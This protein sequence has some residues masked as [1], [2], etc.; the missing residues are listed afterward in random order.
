MELFMSYFVPALCVLIIGTIPVYLLRIIMYFR[1]EHFI[2]QERSFRITMYIHGG[3]YLAFTLGMILV[4]S[5]MQETTVAIYIYLVMA[6]VLVCLYFGYRYQFNHIKMNRYKV[7]Y[8]KWNNRDVWQKMLDER[9]LAN[10]DITEGS[11]SFVSEIHFTSMK[12]SEIRDLLNE[13]RKNQDFVHLLN[14][15]R[16]LGLLAFQVS[17]LSISVVSFVLF[18]VLIP[19]L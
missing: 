14:N 18:F 19:N 2:L 15:K 8:S 5:K 12:D 7:F 4:T 10:V 13:F 3:L 11:F 9:H 6:L 17:M 16:A 1:K